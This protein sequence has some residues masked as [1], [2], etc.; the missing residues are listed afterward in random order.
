MDRV[1]ERIHEQNA[2]FLFD[3]LGIKRSDESRDEYHHE[4][5]EHGE[6]ASESTGMDVIRNDHEDPAAGAE[7]EESIA[8][9]AEDD[10]IDVI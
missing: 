8:A 7:M 5:N 9:R 10:R 3:Y 6:H 4:E 2:P 1:A